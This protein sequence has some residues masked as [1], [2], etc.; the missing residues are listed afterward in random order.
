MSQKSSS[1]LEWFLRRPEDLYFDRL[2]WRRRSAQR[3]NTLLK[4]HYQH[5]TH[6]SFSWCCRKYCFKQVTDPL[7]CGYCYN[8]LWIENNSKLCNILSF[9][10]LK[11]CTLLGPQHA[12]SHLGHRCTMD[13]GTLAAF[14]LHPETARLSR[15]KIF[16]EMRSISNF[17]C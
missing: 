3:G 1:N 4:W 15:L 12:A 13:I 8:A 14:M 10:L 7:V 2:L 11:V 17:E 9:Y 6:Y 5:Y 16:D